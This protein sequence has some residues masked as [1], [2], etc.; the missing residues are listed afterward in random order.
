MLN[1]KQFYV[2]SE[3]YVK[4]NI[5]STSLFTQWSRKPSCP[6]L[7][8]IDAWWCIRAQF[9][10]AIL[11]LQS[12]LKQLCVDTFLNRSC[13]PQ[14]LVVIANKLAQKALFCRTEKSLFF[15]SLSA[16]NHAI[17]RRLSDRVEES[18]HWLVYIIIWIHLK[19]NQ[20]CKR[21][22]SNAT[23]KSNSGQTIMVIID[24]IYS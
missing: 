4:I 12:A 19:E 8:N 1:A 6:R 10:V 21:V 18:S 2:A 23:T 13:L 7:F 17:E 15:F 22:I 3:Y 5:I 9:I 20:I 14:P 24:P 16:K 11:N